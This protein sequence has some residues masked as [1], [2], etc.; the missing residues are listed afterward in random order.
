MTSSTKLTPDSLLD[1]IEFELGSFQDSHYYVHVNGVKKY[2]FY[3]GISLLRIRDVSDGSVI[4][5]AGLMGN[6]IHINVDP[7]LTKRLI[8]FI[9]GRIDSNLC[10]TVK[11]IIDESR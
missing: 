6:D 1:L 8:N 11:G 10:K 3:I 2:K 9:S 4:F 5:E 7:D